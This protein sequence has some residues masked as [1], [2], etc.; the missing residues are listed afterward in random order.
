MRPSRQ[1]ALR[2]KI[3]KKN[4]FTVANASKFTK[5]EPAK[6]DALWA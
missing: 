4:S 6:K 3:L 1:L 2:N 5:D